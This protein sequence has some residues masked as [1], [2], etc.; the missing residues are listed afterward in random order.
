MKRLVTCS[1]STSV[2]NG[3]MLYQPMK[4]CEVLT[5]RDVKWLA[6]TEGI[7][8]KSNNAELYQVYHFRLSPGQALAYSCI[9]KLVE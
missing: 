9:V 1:P 3:Q 8:D 2:S 6:M 5:E 4:E 7:N